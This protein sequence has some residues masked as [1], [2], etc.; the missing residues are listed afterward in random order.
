VWIWLGIGLLMC[1]ASYALHLKISWIKTHL[2]D[3]SYFTQATSDHHMLHYLAGPQAFLGR[4]FSC[5][6][7]RSP[8]PQKLSLNSNEGTPLIGIDMN[9]AGLKAYVNRPMPN[10]RS[11][12]EKKFLGQPPNK[13]EQLFWFDR[14]G[15]KTHFFII[16]VMLIWQSIYTSLFA[17]QFLPAVV[18]TYSLPMVVVYVVVG[19]VPMLAIFFYMT[20]TILE[21]HVVVTSIEM[22]KQTR[23]IRDVIR[24]QKTKK[25][26]RALKML[27]DMSR[28]CDALKKKDGENTAAVD[29]D[30]M[31]PGKLSN[32]LVS[33]WLIEF[34]CSQAQGDGRD[35]RPL[36]HVR[37]SSSRVGE[38]IF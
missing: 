32:R 4:F 28:R 18:S 10:K 2:T 3:F 34:V 27:S 26:V 5:I 17:S 31:D 8:P 20:P 33:Y 19:L 13:H 16:R 9:Q 37:I 23:L 12:L 15:E 35:V 22:K 36:R 11:T 7:G 29:L 6:C 30:K 24:E 14:M 25:A 1:G 21:E 38:L